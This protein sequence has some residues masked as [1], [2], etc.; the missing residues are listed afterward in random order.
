MVD[1]C[2]DEEYAEG[3]WR[4][5]CMDLGV[6]D[7]SSNQLFRTSRCRVNAPSVQ[8]THSL[9]VLVSALRFQVDCVLRTM[10]CMQEAAAFSQ[11]CGSVRVNNVWWRRR[12]FK[13]DSVK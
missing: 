8:K 1:L 3:N 10:E 4:R 2:L 7:H 6:S 5:S 9:S 11:F 13:L 12:I